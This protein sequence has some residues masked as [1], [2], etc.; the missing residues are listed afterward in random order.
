MRVASRLHYVHV[1]SSEELTHYGCH[2]RRGTR[3]MDEIGILS[4]FGGT[5]LHDCWSAYWQYRGA[6]HAICHAHILRE[7]QFF[8]DEAA[9]QQGWAAQMKQ[10][11][12]EIK[13][14]VERVR[15]RQGQRMDKQQCVVYKSRYDEIIKRGLEAH[16]LAPEER[17]E[18]GRGEE[19]RP[20]RS[21]RPPSLNLVLR[22]Q[23]CKTEALRFMHDAR[24]PFTNNLAE[25]DLR[26]I[27]L[28]QKI[29]GCFRA[30]DGSRAFCRIRSFI[31]TMKKQGRE[32]VAELERVFRRPMSPALLGS[33]A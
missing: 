3:A 13:E 11:L 6:R 31:S 10:L 26:M 21:K 24:V 17:E 1:A 18:P 20:A 7:L 14:E 30:P 25:R 28:Q 19:H 12:L 29:S 32:V 16:A 33:S 9:G 15:L 5:L 23:H 4:G 2:T 8:I 22:L 27:R